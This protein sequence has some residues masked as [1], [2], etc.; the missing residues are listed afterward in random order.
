MRKTP[1]D[2]PEIKAPATS[3]PLVCARGVGCDAILQGS[4]LAS[5]SGFPPQRNYTRS[6]RTASPIGL[7]AIADNR[8]SPACLHNFLLLCIANEWPASLFFLS[9]LSPT[10]RHSSP[11]Q[12]GLNVHPRDEP[13]GRPSSIRVFQIRTRNNLV[14][15]NSPGG[16]SSTWM[17]LDSLKPC[18]TKRMKP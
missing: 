12:P 10:P 7:Y 9:P 8:P 5:L 11:G 3:R 14:S 17:K 16:P 4:C 6:L 1:S 15:P 18:E 2:A 13:H